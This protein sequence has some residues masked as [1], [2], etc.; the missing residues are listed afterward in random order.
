MPA[1][2]ERCSFKG[3]MADSPASLRMAID[4]AHSGVHTERDRSYE[5]CLPE[6]GTK[7][8]PE[9]VVLVRPSMKGAGMEG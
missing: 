4:L 5:C 3:V 8:G 2:D 7:T 6:V 1:Q 9:V